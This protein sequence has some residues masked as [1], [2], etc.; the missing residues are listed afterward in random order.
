M[1]VEQLHPAKQVW[2]YVHDG[3]FTVSFDFLERAFNEACVEQKMIAN[4]ERNH[5][6]TIE[7]DPDSRSINIVTEIYKLLEN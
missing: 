4:K 6:K 3:D 1:G 7:I 5:I 2:L